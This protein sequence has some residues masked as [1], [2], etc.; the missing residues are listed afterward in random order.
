M[1][2]SYKTKKLEKET[3]RQQEYAE[4]IKRRSLRSIP[5]YAQ[6]LG[7]TDSQKELF[8]SGSSYKT[9]SKF[10]KMAKE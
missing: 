1:L 5:T 3:A 8:R 7:M 10:K 4:D 2:K 9:V 6:Y